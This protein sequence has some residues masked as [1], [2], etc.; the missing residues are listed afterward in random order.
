M[1]I[2]LDFVTNSSSSSFVCYAI[3]SPELAELI[4]A[5]NCQEYIE[6]CSFIETGPEGIVVN[7][8]IGAF[9]DVTDLDLH[10]DK[11]GL[12]VAIGDTESEYAANDFRYTEEL[13]AEDARKMLDWDMVRSAVED[14]LDD[15]FDTEEKILDLIDELPADSVTCK[16]FEA[17]TDGDSFYGYDNFFDSLSYSIYVFVRED[18]MEKYGEHIDKNPDIKVEGNYFVFSGLD[19]YMWPVMVEECGGFHREKMSGRINYLVV[20]PMYAGEGKV[21]YALEM[22]K[23]GKDIKIVHIDD[24]AATI[25]PMHKALP[26]KSYGERLE[27]ILQKANENYVLTN[28][29]P[30]TYDQF[31]KIVNSSR[32]ILNNIVQNVYPGMNA[33]DFLKEKGFIVLL[34]DEEKLNEILEIAD[35]NFEQTNKRPETF[36]EFADAVGSTKVI[37]INIV[38][39]VHHDDASEWLTQ[40]GYIIPENPEEKLATLL[41]K[42]D[43]HF[44]LT[45]RRPENMNQLL[46]ITGATLS[47]LSSLIKQVH[48]KFSAVDWLTE[49]GYIKP[50][51]D[52]EKLEFIYKKLKERYPEGS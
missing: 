16:I 39:S 43:E 18:W 40:N 26:L 15:D 8:E 52:E 51:T 28:K 1:K 45:A 31:V 48:Q 38:E 24:F 17:Q 37:L 10:I 2:R 11:L 6:A 44:S 41:D 35:K 7:R 21:S 20:N 13:E 46:K 9:F 19:S 30:E 23:K 29:H 42:A 5:C 12:A 49:N 47:N 27:E 14:F 34:S 33:E 25:K 36:R 22:R 4:E 3:R 50:L 32:I